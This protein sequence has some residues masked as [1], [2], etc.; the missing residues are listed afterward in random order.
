MADLAQCACGGCGLAVSNTGSHNPYFCVAC[1]VCMAQTPDLPDAEKAAAAWNRMQ[2]TPAATLRAILAEID[3]ERAARM[4]IEANTSTRRNIAQ[5]SNLVPRV[6]VEGSPAQV[7]FCIE[8]ARHDIIALDAQV[9][10]LRWELACRQPVSR[11]PSESAEYAQTMMRR[12]EQIEEECDAWRN[13][14]QE[15]P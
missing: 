11:I 3:A 2:N 12:A 6:V 5:W 10:Q 9:R 8:D 4:G 15:A 14:L 1:S 7:L 13:A